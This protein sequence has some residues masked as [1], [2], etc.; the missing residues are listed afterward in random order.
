M[1]R[2]SGTAKLKIEAEEAQAALDILR[3]E[4]LSLELELAQSLRERKQIQPHVSS[5]PVPTI[6][7]RRKQPWI[8][9]LSCVLLGGCGELK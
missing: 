7:N 4:A 6:Q 5:I 9:I 3:E 1:E 8:R 2:L